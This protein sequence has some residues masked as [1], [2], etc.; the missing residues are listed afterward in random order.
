MKSQPPE[1]E[2][3]FANKITDKGL[4]SKIYKQLRQ[5]NI[6]KA[7]NSIKNGQET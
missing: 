5:F 1:W 4:T 2:K 3:I 6:K 7:N